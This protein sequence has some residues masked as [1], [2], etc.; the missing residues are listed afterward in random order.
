VREHASVQNKGRAYGCGETAQ[1]QEG[2]DLGEAY[3]VIAQRLERQARA[4][5]VEIRELRKHSRTD[6]DTQ[7]CAC[8]RN[9]VVR[10]AGRGGG[11]SGTGLR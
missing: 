8:E 6:N 4:M 1:V 5:Q 10:E 3:F 2:V 7:R 9:A 11:R